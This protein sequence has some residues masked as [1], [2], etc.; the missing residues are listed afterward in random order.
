[1][2]ISWAL[3]FLA[4]VCVAAVAAG[5]GSSSEQESDTADH[6][7]S[8]TNEQDFDESVFDI[9]RLDHAAARLVHLIEVIENP[10]S[11]DGRLIRASRVA[12]AGNRIAAV[13]QDPLVSEELD[14]I[15]DQL[16]E[17]VTYDSHTAADES[18]TTAF[19]QLLASIETDPSNIRGEASQAL[20]LIWHAINA[21]S[22]NPGLSSQRLAI[23]VDVLPISRHLAMDYAKDW[24]AD[25]RDFR[26][27]DALQQAFHRVTEWHWDCWDFI[28]RC[29]AYEI[30]IQESMVHSLWQAF[31]SEHR[32][33]AAWRFIQTSLNFDLEILFRLI[34][35]LPAEVRRLA[36]ETI[37]YTI[38]FWILDTYNYWP[39]RR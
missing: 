11:V 10:A 15:C 16:I 29:Y 25:I 7:S 14:E 37:I 20:D 23:L 13:C 6:E 8:A 2:Q 19:D 27:P 33:N 12:A 22:H 5:C 34:E 31:A 24:D 26:V 28:S 39:T 1:M 38:N 32:D 17:A 18:A 30:V 9:T 3:A 21:Y 36:S 35:L 4:S